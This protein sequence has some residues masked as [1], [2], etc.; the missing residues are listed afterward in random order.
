MANKSRRLPGGRMRKPLASAVRRRA[1]SAIS[2]PEE[3]AAGTVANGTPAISVVRTDGAAAPA[4]SAPAA[5][6]GPTARRLR[7]ATAPRPAVQRRG[8][9]L[10]DLAAASHRHIRRDLVRIALLATLMLGIIVALSFVLR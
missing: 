6:A 8:P 2:A 3:R 4:R 1:E 5:G 10:L 7:P 9:S